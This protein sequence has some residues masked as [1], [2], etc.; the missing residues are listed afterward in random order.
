MNTLSYGV[1][2][3]QTGDKGSVFF[4]ALEDDLDY[5]NDH[6]HDGV[7]GVKI[8]ATNITAV[9]QSVLSGSWVA[10]SGGTYRQLLTVANGKNFDDVDIVF[11]DSTSKQKM[12]LATEKVSATTFYVYIN[13]NSIGLT[14]SYR[15]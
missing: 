3:P 14:A 13:D 15:S 9:T 5:L 6:A 12:Y 11:R 7:T 4:P 8:T 10:T 2:Q 1:K